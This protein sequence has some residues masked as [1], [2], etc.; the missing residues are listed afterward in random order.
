MYSAAL[1]QANPFYDIVLA[2]T[3]EEGVDSAIRD[4]PDLVIIDLLLPGISGVEV[5]E[6]LK[7][8]GILRGVPLIIA[9]GQGNEASRIAE[10]LHATAFLAKPFPESA[11]LSAVQNAL[12]C[13]I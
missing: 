2:Y 9:S 11:L 13:S 8:E 5:I 1:C 6:K 10:Q 3:G 7:E 4:C 12:S